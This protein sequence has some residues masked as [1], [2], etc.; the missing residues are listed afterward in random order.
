MTRD[1]LNALKL[2]EKYEKYISKGSLARR[3]M[4]QKL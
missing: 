2:E 1:I 3:T 4:L